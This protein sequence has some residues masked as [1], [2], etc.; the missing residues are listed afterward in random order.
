MS[1]LR[2][3]GVIGIAIAFAGCAGTGPYRSAAD[4]LVSKPFEDRCQDLYDWNDDAI[5]K[6]F[7]EAGATSDDRDAFLAKMHDAIEQTPKELQPCWK[8]AYEHH[9]HAKYDLYYVEFDDAGQATD[10]ARDQ[11]TYRQS[12]LYLIENSIKKALHDEKDFGLNVVVFTHGWHG[13]ARADNNYSTEFKAIFQDIA[14]REDAYARSVSENNNHRMPHRVVGIEI[15]WRG[16]SLLTPALPFYP[17]SQNVVN[18][19]DRKLA[20]ETLSTG[21]VQELLA[22]LNEAYLDNRCH[23]T[24]RNRQ[25]SGESC[26]RVHMVSIGHSF[27]ALINYH[28]LTPRLKSGLNVRPSKARATGVCSTMR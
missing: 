3:A 14:V 2:S 10:I 11:A 28:A 27:G 15:A 6:I 26:D 8:T 16:D 22:F 18:I 4:D 9:S 1:L 12:E 5:E 23:G 21:S 7:V 17:P 25:L 19:W 20:A 24:Q 13:N